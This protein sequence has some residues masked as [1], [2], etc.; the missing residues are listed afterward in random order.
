[1]ARIPC[2]DDLAERAGALGGFLF[3]P[4]R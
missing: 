2:S 1:V 4:S 3:V